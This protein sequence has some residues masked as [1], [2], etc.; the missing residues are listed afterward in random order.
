MLPKGMSLFLADIIDEDNG[1]Q[2]F[3]YVVGRTEESAFKRFTKEANKTWYRYLYYFYEVE[4]D[5]EIQRFIE[6]HPDVKAGIY[7][8]W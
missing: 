2:F 1:G 8:K 6:F 3:W 7:N 5:D 4:N